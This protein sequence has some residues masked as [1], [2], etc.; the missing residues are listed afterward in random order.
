VSDLPPPPQV[1]VF[2]RDIL[3]EAIGVAWAWRPVAWGL[4]LADGTTVTGPAES[5]MRGVTLWH[6][7]N[8][9]AEALG[10]VA[11]RIDTRLSLTEAGR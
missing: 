2:Y 1:V 7:V 5:P 10:A 9:A 3:D 11:A 8:D 4:Q 6:S